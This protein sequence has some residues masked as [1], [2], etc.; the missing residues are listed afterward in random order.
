MVIQINPRWLY[1]QCYG[2]ERPN[3]LFDRTASWLTERK[4]LL[5][6]ITTLTRLISRVRTRSDSR[7]WYMLSELPSVE[8]IELLKSLLKPLQDQRYSEK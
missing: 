2:I 4:L 6:G 7:L 1:T 5:P 3:I 8:Q